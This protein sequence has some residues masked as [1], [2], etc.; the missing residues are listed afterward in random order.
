MKKPVPSQ[1]VR[2]SASKPNTGRGWQ[3]NR[4]SRHPLRCSGVYV[5]RPHALNTALCAVTAKAGS[6]KGPA[7]SPSAPPASVPHARHRL[8][9]FVAML[10]R[11]GFSGTQVAFSCH[12]PCPRMGSSD[13]G[14]AGCVRDRTS[15]R[16]DPHGD[17]RCTAGRNGGSGSGPTADASAS[18]LRAVLLL[19]RIRP[20]R[21]GR[22]AAPV[23]RRRAPG[24]LHLGWRDHVPG[25]RTQ[26]R[27][28][29]RLRPPQFF[30]RLRADRRDGP[31][32]P[33]RSTAAG[34]TP[35]Q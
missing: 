6:L 25:L 28:G 19:G 12:M 33:D 3:P 20:A 24:G 5:E 26:L 10:P 27:D 7:F 18:G 14:C 29:G 16:S 31:L 17:V 34:R 9:C 13:S 35:G 8:R 15:R 22:C 21:A 4:R 30:H 32:Q 23:L 1:W 2:H 11:Q